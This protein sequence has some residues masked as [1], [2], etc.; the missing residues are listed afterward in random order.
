MHPELI[1][2][3]YQNPLTAPS[4]IT[5]LTYA[6]H[7][8]VCPQPAELLDLALYVSELCHRGGTIFALRAPLAIFSG[9]SQLRLAFDQHMEAA[10]GRSSRLR[11]T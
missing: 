3:L 4:P 1:E 7:P 9:R 2:P 8:L 5:S 10:D 6:R 11:V